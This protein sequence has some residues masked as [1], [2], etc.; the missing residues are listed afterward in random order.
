[1]LLKTQDIQEVCQ[2]ILTAVDTTENTEITESLQIHVS[3][4]VLKLDVTNR[5][6]FASVTLPVETE[7]VF[8]ATVNASLFLKLMSQ[9]T[10]TSVNFSIADT[11]LVIVANGTYKIPLIYDGEELLKLPEIVINN[12]TNEMDVDSNI[13]LSILQYNSKELTKGIITRAVQKLFYVDEQ[14]AITFTNGACVNTFALEKP[15][16][17]LL[18]NKLVKL[19]K[20]FKGD[21]VHLKLGYDPVGTSEEI[22]QTKLSLTAPDVEITAI[23]P[24]DDTLLDS[25]PVSAIRGRALGEYNYSVVVDKDALISTINRLMVFNFGKSMFKPYGKFDFTE[26]SV[27]VSDV[28]TKNAEV[29]NYLNSASNLSEGY[30]AIFDFND[31]KSTLEVCTDKYVTI[32]FGDHKALIIARGSVYNVI[33]EVKLS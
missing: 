22:I 21:K 19:F 6:Y 14:G 26:D 33:P 11:S 25:Y 18:N 27:E 2:K 17:V 9:I 1:M 32:N 8:N 16:R 10:T 15:I 3:D 23:L 28:R 24:C 20:L 12:V 31:I 13:L 5:E 4:G 29:V 7:E 30:E